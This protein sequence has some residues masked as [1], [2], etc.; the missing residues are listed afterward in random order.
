MRCKRLQMRSHSYMENAS[1]DEYKYT[2]M[3]FPTKKTLNINEIM[4]VSYSTPR[5][6]PS[7][8]KPSFHSYLHWPDSRIDLQSVFICSWQ[9]LKKKKNRTSQSHVGIAK[10]CCVM[11]ETWKLRWLLLSNQG[12][13]SSTSVRSTAGRSCRCWHVPALNF[14]V[15]GIGRK[16]L[17]DCPRAALSWEPNEGSGE[18]SRNPLQRAVLGVNWNAS[19][20]PP[21]KHKPNHWGDLIW[22]HL[23]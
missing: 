4:K 17:W 16:S 18:E 14:W 3:Q 21:R 13:H 20:D 19:T 23:P 5:A 22:S 10:Q 2:C 12:P 6:F 9:Q 1:C 8:K 15:K 11:G 7:P